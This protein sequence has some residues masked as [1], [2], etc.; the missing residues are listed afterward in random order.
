M[1]VCREVRGVVSVRAARGVVSVRALYPGDTWLWGDL[2]RR[3][4]CNV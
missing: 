3:E 1:E 4:H 2:G